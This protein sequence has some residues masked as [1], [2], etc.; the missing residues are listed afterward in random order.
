M[1]FIDTYRRNVASKREELAR[2]SRD[3]ANEST[4]KSSIQSKI[5]AAQSAI[6]R[7][8]II[9]TINSKQ[10]EIEQCLKSLADVEKKIAAIDGK[11]ASK[12]RELVNEERRVRQEEDRLNRKRE[13]EDKKR[14]QDNERQLRTIN[15]SLQ[16]QSFVQ[17]YLSNEIE[18]LKYV[19][20]KITVLFFAINP[21]DTDRLRLDAEVRSIQEIIR[22]SE[23]R[24]SISFE[25]RWAVQPL[26]IFQAINELNPD[27]I[28][29]SGHGTD[30]GELVLE[31]PDGSAK[32]VSKESIAQTISV[33][34][35]K[36]HLILFNACFSCEQAQAV[37]E[38]VD[39]AIG[40]KKSISDIGAR[41]FAAQFYSAL[42]FGRTLKNAF[43]QAKA[44]LTIES[45][46]DRDIPELYIKDGIEPDDMYIVK[47][48]D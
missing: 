44:A 33:F 25:S 42:G 10:K 41:V 43:E 31:N 14:A 5:H 46:V 32:Y 38:H 13:M 47:P 30:T 27:V 26:D 20:E 9:S 19:P 15:Q 1:S 12:E 39:A 48:T 40:M 8:K 37:T 16:H 36:I 18:M 45:P 17:Q 11:I 7:T 28:H 3:K 6:S 22:K 29:F 24:D 21:K 4:K 35:D 34:S 23:H 2:L